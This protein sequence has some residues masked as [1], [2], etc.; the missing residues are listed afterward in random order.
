VGQPA[1]DA[2]RLRTAIVAA[3]LLGVAA[4]A[5]VAVVALSRDGAPAPAPPPGPPP[6]V[7]AFLSDLGGPELQRL[8]EVGD[9]IDVLA[10]NWHAVSL[11]TGV[12]SGPGRRV[13]VLR[14]ARRGRIAVWPVVNAVGGGRFL[15]DRAAR[16]RL[17]EQLARLP[18]AHGYAGVTLDM[19]EIP[20]AERAGFTALVA[21]VARRVHAGG[22]G[23]AV[24]VPRQTDADGDRAYDWPALARHAD[25]LLASGYNEHFSGGPAGPVTTPAGFAAVA[26]RAVRIAGPRAAPVVGAFGYRWPAGGGRATMLSAVDAE[27]LRGRVGADALHYNSAA[28]LRAQVAAARAAGA[29]WVALFSL[30]REPAALWQALGSREPG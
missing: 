26:R 24:Y 15:T 27:A 2:R 16:G 3:A 25:L 29:R 8:R 1:A 7:F 21:D 11:R 12:F 17:A 14:E 4:I 5:V 28:D 22:R 10:P 9:R 20:A 6:R 19:E 13:A 30:G 18:R 23:L